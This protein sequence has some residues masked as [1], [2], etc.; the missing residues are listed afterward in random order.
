MKHFFLLIRWWHELLAIL[1]FGLLFLIIKFNLLHK[2]ISCNLLYTDF[3]VICFCV[4]L[5]MASGFIFNDIIDRKIDKVNKPDKYIIDRTISLNLAIRY[6]VFITILVIGI[7]IYIISFIFK[8]WI[9]FCT[10]VY[11]LSIIY[12]LYLKKLPLIGNVVIAALASFIPIILLFSTKQC[13]TLI[14][15]NKITILIY[16]YAIF[17]FSIIIPREISL[18]MEDIEGDKVG[19]CKTIPI[20]IGI[21][22]TKQ[23]INLMIRLGMSRSIV[24]I[25]KYSYFKLPYILVNGLL[26]FYLYKF[27][28]SKTKDEYKNSRNLLWIIMILGLVGFAISTM[29]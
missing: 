27:N 23:I 5:L 6:F 19:H 1:P 16:L 18:D 28:K 22:K 17:P 11:I 20:L 24:I 4:Q 2:N 9:F 3:A 21:K 12:S 15:D 7:S 13:L 26:V 29:Y 14:S 10:G 25:C 8:E